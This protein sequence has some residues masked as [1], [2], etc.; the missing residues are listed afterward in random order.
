MLVTARMGVCNCLP[1]SILTSVCG[2]RDSVQ[3]HTGLWCAAEEHEGS[4]L[5]ICCLGFKMW[6]KFKF[7]QEGTARSCGAKLHPASFTRGNS[8]FL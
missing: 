7:E 3:S 6:P 4:P 5:F 2:G 8:S 1:P